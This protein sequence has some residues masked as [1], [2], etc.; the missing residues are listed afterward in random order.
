MQ[1][2]LDSDEFGLL[3]RRYRA[4]YNSNLELAEIAVK[5]YI[6]DQIAQDAIETYSALSLLQSEVA[7]NA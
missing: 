5:D 2:W 4:A 6:R 1:E 7:G 3:L